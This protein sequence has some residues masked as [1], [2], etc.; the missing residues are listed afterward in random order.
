MAD[1]TQ[2]TD[3]TETPPCSICGQTTHTDGWH[4]KADQTDGW[5]HKT[6]SDA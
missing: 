4:H 2:P 3:P 1:S 5:H 6:E